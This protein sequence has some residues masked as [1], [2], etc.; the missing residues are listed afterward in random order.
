MQNAWDY[1]YSEGDYKDP[2]GKL[3]KQDCFWHHELSYKMTPGDEVEDMFL[4]LNEVKRQIPAIAAVSSGA[5]ASDYQRLR[6]ESVCSRL[7]LVSLSYLWK[8]EQSLLFQEM[9]SSGIVAIIV[10]VAAIGLHPAKHLGKELAELQSHL[11]HLNG[12]YGSNVCGEGGE[13]ETLTLDCPL[14]KFAR[15]VL[16]DFQ[17]IL[18]SPDSIAPVGV[19]HPL[20]FH[21]EPKGLSTDS[22]DSNLSNGI[23]LEDM[24]GVYEIQGDNTLLPADPSQ[25]SDSLSDLIANTSYHLQM[26]KIDRGDTFSICCWLQDLHRLSTGLQTD[27]KV[28]LSH[29]ESQLMQCGFSWEDVLYIHMYIAD[30]NEFA[31]ANETYVSYITQEKC[32]FGVPSRSTVEL[33]L[34]QAGL[35]KAYVEVLV[36]RDK[37]KNVLHVQSISRW[38]PS[39]IGP[40]SQAT[41][42]HGILHMAGQ[43]GLDPPTMTLCDDGIIS[44]LDQALLNSEAIADSFRCSISSSAISFVVYCSIQTVSL[45]RVDM[46]DKWE[47]FL[48]QLKKLHSAKRSGFK[49]FDPILLF[50]LVPQLPKRALVEVKPTLFIVEDD[51]DTASDT[52]QP[53]ASDATPQ[54]YWGFQEDPWHESCLQKCVM[55]KHICAVM[56]SITSENIAKICDDS[57][58]SEHSLSEG[59]TEKVAKFC[60]YLINKILTENMFSWEHAM[61]LRIYFQTGSL[62]QMEMLSLTF[63][64]AFKEFGK[65]NPKFN[66]GQADPIFNLIPV[67]GSGRSALSIDAVLTCELLAQKLSS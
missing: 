49:V 22:S 25:F 21:L 55:L 59:Q 14:F 34:L 36:S 12:L 60:I 41:L 35:G 52:D 53:D 8:Q 29:L 40:Y 26:S 16:D 7:G 47:G 48:E 66:S 37:T 27:L 20:A 6:V 45:N 13:Y 17:V 58:V 2:P 42:H 32:R 9:I 64:Q 30:M 50:V 57:L 1:H 31:V 43:L 46:Q 39:C 5:I 11:H 65:I 67:L 24:D 62:V 51:S 38:A 28:V 44:E 19:L 18:H 10:K 63:S 54:S 23:S 61:Y 33:P 56:L 4:L 15:I 3:F